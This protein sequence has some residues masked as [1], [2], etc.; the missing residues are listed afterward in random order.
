MMRASRL[1][2]CLPL[3]M[4]RGSRLAAIRSARGRLRTRRGPGSDTR[5]ALEVDELS[6]HLGR[7]GDQ[8]ILVPVE[9]SRSKLID[10]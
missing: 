3:A 4:T 7:L 9:H 10:G 8:L 1:A 2:E 5:W 6:D